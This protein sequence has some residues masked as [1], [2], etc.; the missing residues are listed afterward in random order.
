[1]PY[2]TNTFPTHT[3]V[4]QVSPLSPI[5]FILYNAYLVNACNLLT[6]PSTG[7][8]FVYDVNALAFNKTTEDN[9]RTLQSL[10][11]HFL[12]WARRHG[13]SFA[14]DKYILMHITKSMI[15]HNTA[16]LLTLPSFIITPSLSPRV[17]E[18]IRDNKL[19]WQ[20]HLQHIRSKLAAQT[21][22][23][24][25]LKAS[26]WGGSQQFSRLLYT[27]VVHRAITTGCRAWWAPLDILFFLKGVREEL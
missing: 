21:N 27:A 25:R 2:N 15:K 17:L 3:S 26:T 18:V 16:C 9:C 10:H 12:G 5:H 22:I 11:E 4:S 13:A 19:S 1:M 20:L 14:P 6:V 24:E 23:V 7:I 8:G